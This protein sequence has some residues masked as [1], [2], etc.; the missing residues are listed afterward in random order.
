MV[1]LSNIIEVLLPF[2]AVRNASSA[3]LTAQIVLCESSSFRLS[4]KLRVEVSDTNH[5]YSQPDVLTPLSCPRNIL[6]GM[7]I[8]LSVKQKRRMRQ[9]ARILHP[10][11]PAGHLKLL[12]QLSKSL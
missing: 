11:L 10:T 7:A 3:T 9:G 2:Y 5:I 4:A 12:G 8:S 6:S 1:I